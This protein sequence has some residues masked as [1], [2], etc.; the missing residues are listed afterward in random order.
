VTAGRAIE[1]RM[2]GGLFLVQLNETRTADRLLD[3]GDPTM[4]GHRARVRAI[5]MAAWEA[6]QAERQGVLSAGGY[7]P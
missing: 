4:A 3:R 6:E 1:I 5:G 2:G 7:D